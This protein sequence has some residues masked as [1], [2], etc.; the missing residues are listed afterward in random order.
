MIHNNCANDDANMSSKFNV[1][2]CAYTYTEYQKPKHGKIKQCY[3][4]LKQD[5][6]MFDVIVQ[7]ITPYETEQ[8]SHPI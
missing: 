5:V 7:H 4:P 2:H 3:E 1:V 6:E 8:H